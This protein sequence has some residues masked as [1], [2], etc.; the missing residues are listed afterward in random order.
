M[1]DLRWWI[2]QAK[3]ELS[4]KI[5]ILPGH[6]EE[7]AIE[8]LEME[9]LEAKLKKYIKEGEEILKQNKKYNK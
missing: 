3:K 9:E 7:M 6:K 1:Q 2:S 5:D 4:L 8:I